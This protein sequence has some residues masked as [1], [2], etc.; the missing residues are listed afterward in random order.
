[1]IDFIVFSALDG[2]ILR[3]GSC[4]A[5]ILPMQAQENELVWQ[6][7]YHDPDLY[8]FEDDQPCLRPSVEVET[9]YQIAAD[10]V[11]AVEIALPAGSTVIDR[12]TR[13]WFENEDEIYFSTEVPGVTRYHVIPPMPFREFEVKIDAA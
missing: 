7:P 13:E 9:E 11:E 3:W 2:R 5:Y 12:Q 6:G 10:G 8:Y 4:E 1:M